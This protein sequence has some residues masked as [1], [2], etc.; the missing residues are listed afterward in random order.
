MECTQRLET[1]S[2]HCRGQHVSVVCLLCRLCSRGWR[3]VHFY[4]TSNKI[5]FFALTNT[6]KTAVFHSIEV[7]SSAMFPSLVNYVE[8]CYIMLCCLLQCLL[9]YISCPKKY[10]YD[11]VNL[12]KIHTIRL[13]L[14][15]DSLTNEKCIVHLNSTITQHFPQICYSDLLYYCNHLQ[16]CAFRTFKPH[17]QQL[18]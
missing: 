12:K 15:S 16:I 10:V 6:F 17:F 11:T 14:Q 9:S 2:Q 8:Q 18:C 4:P 3:V 1:A 13:F 7:L 5:A